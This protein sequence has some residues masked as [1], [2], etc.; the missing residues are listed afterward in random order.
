MMPDEIYVVFSD[1]TDLWWLKCLRRGFRHCFVIMRFAD[2][3]MALD[4]LAHKTEIMR[5]DIP[6]AFS[7][8]GWLESQGERVVC[9]SAQKAELKPLFPAPCS[10]VEMVKRV[11][12]LRQFFIFT[13]WQLFNFL[14]EQNE[15]I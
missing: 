13:P 10:C 5:I 8:I 2:I 14:K 7:L 3:W 1:Q 4:P 11:L 15:R 12:G 6:D 9:V